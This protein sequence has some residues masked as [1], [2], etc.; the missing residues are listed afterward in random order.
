MNCLG[1]PSDATFFFRGAGGDRSSDK[2]SCPNTLGSHPQWSGPFGW[3]SKTMS[4]ASA[5]ITFSV[6]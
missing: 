6:N 5:Y 3:L 4:E 2:I 1:G